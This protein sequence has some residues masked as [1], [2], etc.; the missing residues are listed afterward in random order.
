M[1]RHVLRHSYLFVIFHNRNIY[2][3]MQEFVSFAIVVYFYV[4]IAFRIFI[5]FFILTGILSRGNSQFFMDLKDCNF[6]AVNGNILKIIS[7][8]AWNSWF[9]NSVQQEDINEIC[10]AHN[11][12]SHI[13]GFYDMIY[14]LTLCHNFSFIPILSFC[15][16]LCILLLVSR[17]NENIL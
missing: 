9:R 14:S 8:E 3:F 12:T 16:Y 15:S 13:C 7:P 6:I 1:F 5:T 4:S 2:N 10:D 17:R 11:K